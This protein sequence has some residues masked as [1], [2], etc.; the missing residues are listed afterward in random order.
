MDGKY[1][2]DGKDLKKKCLGL[3]ANI[4]RIGKMYN[5]AVE[6]KMPGMPG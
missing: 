5:K 3:M 1:W 6:M 2:R 4:K